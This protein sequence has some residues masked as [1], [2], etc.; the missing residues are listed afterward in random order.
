MLYTFYY[1][2]IRVITLKVFSNMN[3]LLTENNVPWHDKN[4]LR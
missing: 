2:F 4:Y 3:N 1:N